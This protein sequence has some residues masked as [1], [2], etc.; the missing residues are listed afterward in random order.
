MGGGDENLGRIQVL[1]INDVACILHIGIRVMTRG[2]QS[3]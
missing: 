1:I 3:S 2:G